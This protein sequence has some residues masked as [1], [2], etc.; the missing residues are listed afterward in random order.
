MWTVEKLRRAFESLE[1]EEGRRLQTVLDW[2]ISN[3]FLVEGRTQFPG[4]GLRG[5]GKERILT[6]CSN[7]HIFL[8]FVERKYPGGTEERDALV[9]ELKP[10]GMLDPDI[11]PG[12][13]VE[14]R[15]LPRKLSE[16]DDSELAKLFDVLSQYCG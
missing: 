10:L 5:K 2:A 3:R 6:V 1:N 9:N 11:D 4:F 15:T 16:L 7:G 13:V 12:E 8:F 14:G